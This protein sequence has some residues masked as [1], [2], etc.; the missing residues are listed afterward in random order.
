MRELFIKNYNVNFVSDIKVEGK[1][2]H[3]YIE[4]SL[5]LIIEK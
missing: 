1:V 3:F 5:Q 4:V 2:K